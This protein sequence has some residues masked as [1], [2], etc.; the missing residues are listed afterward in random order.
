MA[1]PVPGGQYQPGYGLVVVR[2][3]KR[4]NLKIRR[5]SLLTIPIYRRPPSSDVADEMS[6]HLLLVSSDE[7]KL[8]PHGLLLV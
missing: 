4:D 3:K 7:E 2:G 6:P 8:H 5:R 1:P